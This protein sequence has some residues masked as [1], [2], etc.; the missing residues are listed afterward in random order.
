VPIF[1]YW[2]NLPVILVN[3]KKCEKMKRKIFVVVVV[4][5]VHAQDNNRAETAWLLTLDITLSSW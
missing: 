1:C 2:S 4:V 5:L 3:A